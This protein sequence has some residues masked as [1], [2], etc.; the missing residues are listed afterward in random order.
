[1]AAG[2]VMLGVSNCTNVGT[3]Y[4]KNEHLVVVL[5]NGVDKVGL[6]KPMHFIESSFSHINIV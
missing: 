5:R 3:Y 4:L 2:I 1:M 6:K